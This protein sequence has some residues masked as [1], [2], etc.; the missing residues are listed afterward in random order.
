MD[1]QSALADMNI[2]NANIDGV[3]GPETRQSVIEF[4]QNHQ[5]KSDGVVGPKTWAAIIPD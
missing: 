5:L 3:F 2:F 4:Q 1:L